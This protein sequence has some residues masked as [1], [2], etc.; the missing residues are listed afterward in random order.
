MQ[1]PPESQDHCILFWYYELMLNRDGKEQVALCRLHELGDV[2]L[3]KASYCTHSFAKHFHECY[4]FGVIESG[5][6]GFFYRGKNVVA[7]EGEINLAI[8]GESHDGFA[9]AEHGW[10]YRMLY[11]STDLVSRAVSEVTDKPGG[12]PFFREGVIQDRALAARIRSCHVSLE[13]RQASLLEKETSLLAIIV[14]LVTRHA[15]EKPIP[16]KAPVGHRSVGRAREYLHAH[17]GD[18]ISLEKLST[19]AGLSRYHLLRLF[20]REV[21]LPPHAYLIQVRVRKAKEL[22]TQGMPLAEVAL[23]TGFCDQSH[24]NRLFKRVVGVAPGEYSKIVQ[25]A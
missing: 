14:D 9:A 12:L 5:A 24:L 22:M 20:A 7:S 4:A 18:K 2:E 10:R 6:L 21:G 1:S 8:P 3:L 16:S 17:Y 13:R 19:V 23:C 15:E 11:V 25:D